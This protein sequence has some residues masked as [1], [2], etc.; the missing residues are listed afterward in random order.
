MNNYVRFNYTYMPGRQQIP[1]FQL[2]SG[3]TA[4]RDGSY[5]LTNVGSIFYN[6]DTS[7]VEI[8]HE[9]PSNNAAWRDLVV[10]NRN[11]T[12]ISGVKKVTFSDGTEQTTAAGGAPTE[13]VSGNSKV[14]IYNPPAPGESYPHID[15]IAGNAM[16]GRFNAYPESLE[17]NIVEA[18]GGYSTLRMRTSYNYVILYTSSVQCQRECRAP[19][20]VVSSD[21]R[22]KENETYITNATDTIKKLTPQRYVKYETMDLSGSS[23]VETGL[24]SQSVWYNAPELRHL[25]RLGTDTD[26]SGNEYTPTP[27]ELDLSGNDIQNDIDYGSHGWSRTNPSSLDYTGLIPYLIKSNQELEE[28]ISA[29]EN[30]S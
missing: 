16:I 15:M 26:A 24:I 9:D 4:E 30:I 6:T 28:R 22:L 19:A 1:S 21:D 20:F 13:I 29:L 17:V 27:D 25:V 7:N 2:P 14:K 18:R 5:N 12:D 3:T 8:R 23:F 10:N 11:G